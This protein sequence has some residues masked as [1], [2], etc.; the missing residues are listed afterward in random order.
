RRHGRSNERARHDRQ[1][2]S[3][4][5]RGRHADAVSRSLSPCVAVSLRRAH[6]RADISKRRHVRRLA[7]VSVTS[8]KL[9]LRHA[10][11]ASVRSRERSKSLGRFAVLWVFVLGACTG[12]NVQMQGDVPTPLVNQLPLR[13]GLYLEPALT[14][15]VFEEKI[16]DHGDW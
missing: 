11:F 3:A 8:R 9:S 10:E 5:Q 6:A 2:A 13:I 1:A 7:G 12:A 14:Q 15:Y 16:Q 4:H